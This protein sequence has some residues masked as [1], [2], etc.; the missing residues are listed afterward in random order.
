MFI[1]N[2]E[3]KPEVDHIDT[4]PSNNMVWNLRWATSKENSNNPLTLQHLSESM[5]GKKLSNETKQKASESHKKNWQNS[6]YKQRQSESHK[7]EKNSMYGKPAVNKG[8]HRVYNDP[9]NYK[10]GYH[11]E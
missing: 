2:P 4:N 10:S 7:G 8:K 6:E 1:P 5:K 11:Y 3:N 9:N